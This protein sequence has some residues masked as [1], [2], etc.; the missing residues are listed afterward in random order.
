MIFC[1]QVLY[2]L[3]NLQ[4]LKAKQFIWTC[5]RCKTLKIR[6]RKVNDLELEDMS[7]YEVLCRF[8]TRTRPLIWWEFQSQF[9]KGRR[10]LP[11][12]V[13]Y[14]HSADLKI[15]AT[16]LTK[17]EWSRKA[18]AERNGKPHNQG[19][20][21]VNSRKKEWVLFSHRQE[22]KSG[23]FHVVLQYWRKV[24]LDDMTSGSEY[25]TDIVLLPTSHESLSV[26]HRVLRQRDTNEERKTAL[27]L[28][29]RHRH[30]SR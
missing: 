19:G 13:I 6:P 10:N 8:S 3:L 26:G 2:L 12:C 21:N 17:E 29:R 22:G 4:I 1:F 18:K 15:I 25:I 20:Y 11:K 7:E 23:N 27:V 16:G 24:N 14:L 9:Q 28:H 5:W 30:S